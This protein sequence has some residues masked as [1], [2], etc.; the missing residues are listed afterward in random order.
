MMIILLMNYSLINW[1]FLVNVI[2]L[3]LI[4]DQLFWGIK[5]R[6]FIKVCLTLIVHKIGSFDANILKF[7]YHI[8]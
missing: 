2:F 6:V 8:V 4:G 5:Y 3:S 7:T 1:I